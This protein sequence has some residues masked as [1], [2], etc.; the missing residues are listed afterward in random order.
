MLEINYKRKQ[1]KKYH[2]EVKQYAT[3]EPMDDGRNQ[4]INKKNALKKENRN[5]ISLKHHYEQS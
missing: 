3:K 5:R 1:T 4:R 2:M